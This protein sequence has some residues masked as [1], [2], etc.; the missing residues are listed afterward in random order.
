MKLQC[1]KCSKPLTSDMYQAKVHWFPGWFSDRIL[2]PGAIYNKDQPIYDD[3]DGVSE[4]ILERYEWGSFKR[5]VFYMSQGQK[6]ENN[7][8]CDD[9]PAQIVRKRASEIVVGQSSIFDGIIPPFKRGHGCCNYSMGEKLKCECG[10]HIGHMYLDCYEDGSVHF[11]E[12]NVT[13]VY[14]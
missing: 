6:K 9:R 14:K 11:V 12:K 10:N 13:R 3:Q 5:G 2:N 1:S 7:K 4:G 8:Y